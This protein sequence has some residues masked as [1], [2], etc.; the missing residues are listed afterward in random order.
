MAKKTKAAQIQTLQEMIRGGLVYSDTNHT[1]HVK[2]HISALESLYLT[3]DTWQASDVQTR[4]EREFEALRAS[5]DK[6][7]GQTLR[8][9]LET[10]NNFP[11]LNHRLAII[12]ISPQIYSYLREENR[13]LGIEFVKVNADNIVKRWSQYNSPLWK[14]LNGVYDD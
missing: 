8:N 5:F 11:K 3:D 12:G 6:D 2:A 4:L 14:T 1:D 10:S 7:P 9:I 13:L